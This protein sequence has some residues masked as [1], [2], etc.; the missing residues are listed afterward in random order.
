MSFCSIC[1]STFELPSRNAQIRAKSS[2]FTPCHLGILLMILKNNKA[3]LYFK[4]CASFLSHWWIQTKVTAWKHSIRFKIDN[5]L[6][7][8]TLKVDGWPWK[9]SSHF[10]YAC[11]GIVHNLKATS[12]LKLRLLFGNPHFESKL[13]MF[14][15]VWPWKL[16]DDIEKQQDTPPVPHQALCI[17]SSPYVNSNALEMAKLGFDLWDLDLWPLA[18]NFWMN[19]TFVYGNHS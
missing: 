19:I 4:L 18:L 7:C 5:F 1:E 14:C 12:E 3:P 6:S 9:T 15:P 11:P 17:I 2:V 16:R 8:V 13:A 10:F